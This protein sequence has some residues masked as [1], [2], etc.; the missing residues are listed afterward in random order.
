MIVVNGY[1]FPYWLVGEQKYEHLS[2]FPQSQDQYSHQMLL[3]E[4]TVVSK[5]QKE[6]VEVTLLIDAALVSSCEELPVD[7]VPAKMPFSRI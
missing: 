7:F 1:H 6:E 3:Y 4:P 2:C 5:S